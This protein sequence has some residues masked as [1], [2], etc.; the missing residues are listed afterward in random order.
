MVLSGGGSRAAYQVGALRA[1]IPYL[2]VSNQP[3]ST[4]VGSSIGAVNGLV[5]AACLKDGLPEAVQQLEVL[6]RER[7]FRNTFSGSPSKAFLRAIRMAIQQYSAPGPRATSQAVFDPTPLMQRLDS[8]ISEH[9]GLTPEGRDPHLTSVAVMTTIEGKERRPML[10][11]STHR[12]LDEATL[13]GASFEI[14]Y[15]DQLSAKHGFA[16][17]ALPSVLPPV[18]LDTEHGTVSLVD[19]GIS[20]NIPVDPAVRLGASKV[21]VID[22]SGRHWWLD[23]YGEAHDTRPTWE[24]PA[25]VETFC[26][27]PPA[28]LVLRCQRPLGPILKQAVGTSTKRFMAAIGPMW[29]VFSLLRKK[30]G[31]EL[32]YEVVSYVALDSDYLIGLIERGYNETVSLLRSS[33]EL[34]FKRVESCEPAA[35]QI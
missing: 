23:H 15:V 19:G 1:L 17:A 29:P 16:S 7:N 30:M 18:Q 34:Q 3:I 13:R 8:V 28:T 4:I 11:A 21:V 12:R 24:I 2:G 20:Q 25:A 26:L 33:K 14:C 27:R 5:L 32:A 6:W 35:T 10:F 22:I 31:E 9:G